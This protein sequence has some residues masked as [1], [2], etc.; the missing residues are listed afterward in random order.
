MIQGYLIS[1]SFVCIINAFI[2][3]LTS[4]LIKQPTKESP[5]TPAYYVMMV[6]NSI[7]CIVFCI[8]LIMGISMVQVPESLPTE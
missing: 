4:M 3:S 5:A 1:A 6:I 7:F 8:L 2:N